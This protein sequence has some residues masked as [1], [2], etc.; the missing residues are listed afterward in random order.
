MPYHTINIHLAEK[1]EWLFEANPIGKVPALQLVDQPNAPFIY[2]SMLIAEYLDE[3]HPENK[4][5]PSDPFKKVQEKLWIARFDSL[6]VKFYAHPD[7][8]VALWNDI[9]T[10]F[11]EFERELTVRDTLYFG[12][13]SPNVLDY[14]MWPWFIRTEVL[15]V[16]FGPGCTFSEKRFPKLVSAW[17]TFRNIFCSLVSV[18]LRQD[19]FS[20]FL[21]R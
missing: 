2:E 17:K 14:A 18:T 8:R 12:G 4:L 1:P 10:G 19:R 16:L 15:D 7:D 6:A 20:F 13:S 11:D 9:Q 21:N 5:Y 3:V